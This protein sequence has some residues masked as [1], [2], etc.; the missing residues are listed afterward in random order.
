MQNKADIIAEVAFAER[1][2]RGVKQ[3]LMLN[4]KHDKVAILDKLGI[5]KEMIAKAEKQLKEEKDTEI[6]NKIK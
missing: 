4:T 2:L 5:A 1:E 3:A 6:K